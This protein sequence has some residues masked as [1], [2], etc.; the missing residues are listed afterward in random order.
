[1]AVADPVTV[2][3]KGRP[4]YVQKDRYLATVAPNITNLALFMSELGVTVSDV[5]SL[6]LNMYAF[7]ERGMSADNLS[8]WSSQFPGLLTNVEPD[9]MISLD[10]L[11]PHAV[12]PLAWQV[13]NTGQS[14]YHVIYPDL[15][16]TQNTFQGTPGADSNVE[17]A[18]QLTQGAPSVYVATIDTGVDS[19]NPVFTNWYGES[20][21]DMADAYNVVY[22]A[23]P[24]TDVT[25]LDTHG[26]GVAGVIGAGEA[27]GTNGIV[28]MDWRVKIIPTKFV[29]NSGLPDQHGGDAASAVAAINR[30]YGLSVAGRNIVAVNASWGVTLDSYA[31]NTIMQAIRNLMSRSILFV[32]VAGNGADPQHTNNWVGYDIDQTPQY[33]GSFSQDLGNVITLAAIT[34]QDVLPVWSNWGVNSV[35][36]A[37]PGDSIYTAGS[38][39]VGSWYTWHSGTSF[40]APVVTGIIALEAAKNPTAGLWQ[41][42]QAVID[43]AVYVPALYQKVL[44][45]GRADAYN[46]VF[47]I[48]Q[49]FAPIGSIDVATTTSA[50]GW[51]YDADL[52][53]IGTHYQIWSSDQ[54]G[55]TLLGQGVTD[56]SRH[57]L[58]PYIGGY[59]VV[60][61]DGSVTGANKA[62]Y[63][64]TFSQSATPGSTVYLYVENDNS[65]YVK[66]ASFQV[67][68]D[69]DGMLMLF[70]APA[71]LE[72]GGTAQA[73]VAGVSA[74]LGDTPVAADVEPTSATGTP[75]AAS[76]D[77]G[78]TLGDP[79]SA[80]ATLALID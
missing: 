45:A 50:T 4:A 10:A 1:M 21:L 79:Q 33:P 71:P 66:V 24:T 48:T 41:R 44:T 57:D 34:N 69:G 55:A 58:I 37:A 64:I 20:N 6:G 18:W 27:G 23:H 74:N 68:D 70:A 16:F 17:A 49:D 61:G 39:S 8:A 75:D 78:Y 12:D 62:G 65:N 54:P 5:A 38:S 19:T 3:F 40:A 26:S 13:S 52:G 29:E 7:T 51:A 11:P 2:M 31:K 73:P 9:S 36:L 22:P 67:S 53:P 28:G 63:S 76:F 43:G 32:T 77:S 46:S 59:A 60:N 47:K 15:G 42:R 72:P 30:V 25:D 35:Q 56:T 14:L 80:E